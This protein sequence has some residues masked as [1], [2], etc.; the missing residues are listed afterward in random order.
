MIMVDDRK[1]I[2]IM[3]AS[4]ANAD[5]ARLVSMYEKRVMIYPHAGK[6]GLQPGAGLRLVRPA[7]VP[8]S[9]MASVG[10]APGPDV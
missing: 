5:S 4:S 3:P 10:R 6:A 7:A 8:C 9:A 2:P 1:I